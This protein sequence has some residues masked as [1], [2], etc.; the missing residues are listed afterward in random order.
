M[1]HP[2]D[3]CNGQGFGVQS[4]DPDIEWVCHACDGLGRTP[5]DRWFASA[6]HVA[7]HELDPTEARAAWEKGQHPDEYVTGLNPPCEAC[8]RPG[9]PPH[10]PSTKCHYRGAVTH[11]TCRACWG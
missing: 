1:I 6:E 8:K 7:G 11:C 5:F 2:C 9:G 10:E 4:K 3:A